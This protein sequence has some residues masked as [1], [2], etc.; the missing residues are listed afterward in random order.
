[1]A[2]SIFTDLLS[3]LVKV[4]IMVDEALYHKA[5]LEAQKIQTHCIRCYNIGYINH[6]EYIHV[7]HL[8]NELLNTCRK[9]TD[10]WRKA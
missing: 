2:N 10:N 9:C 5:G 7:W 4:S 3:D 1:M 8:A 6:E